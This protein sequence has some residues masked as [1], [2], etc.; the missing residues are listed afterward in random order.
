MTDE[1]LVAKKLAFIDTC[2]RELE[3]LANPEKL[4][5]DIRELRF[6]EHTLQLAIQAALDVASH[7]V[8]DEEL[9]EPRTN[10]D[11]FQ[12]LAAAGWI[13]AE[14][15]TVLRAAV[16]FRNVLVHGYTAVDV[17]IVRE[18]LEHRLSDLLAFTDAI[19]KRLKC[20]PK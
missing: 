5:T 10:Y 1:D 3:E 13:S 7:I 14:I 16:G 8:S 19:R 6:V 9:G 11:L 12:T 2:V 17:G 20:P 15:G 18:V 4:E